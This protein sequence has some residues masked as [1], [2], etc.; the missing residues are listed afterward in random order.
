M[1]FRVNFD[2][3][4]TAYH[5]DSSDAAI[6]WVVNLKRFVYVRRILPPSDLIFETRMFVYMRRTFSSSFAIVVV[7]FVSILIISIWL[8]IL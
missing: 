8:T 4:I 2:A 3:L 5:I 1:I 6:V 7:V